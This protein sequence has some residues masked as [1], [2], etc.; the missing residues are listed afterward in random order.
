MLLA[1]E[2]ARITS[3][4]MSSNIYGVYVENLVV[5]INRKN[6]CQIPENVPYIVKRVNVCSVLQKKLNNV[7]MIEHGCCVQDRDAHHLK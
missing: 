6:N 5:A 2:A 3:V 4:E 1:R 7:S